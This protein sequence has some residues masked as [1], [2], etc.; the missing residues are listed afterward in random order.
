MWKGGQLAV[1]WKL[2]VVAQLVFSSQAILFS[3]FTSAPLPGLFESPCSFY[4]WPSEVP[5]PPGKKVHA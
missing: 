1:S 5:A 3:T 2:M 4:P